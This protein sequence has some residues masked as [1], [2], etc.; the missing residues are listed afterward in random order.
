MKSFDSEPVGRIRGRKRPT[1]I[2]S[3]ESN[4]NVLSTIILPSPRRPEYQ[5]WE[6]AKLRQVVGSHTGF[7]HSGGKRVTLL[8]APITSNIAAISL[9]DSGQTLGGFW[10]DHGLTIG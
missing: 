5:F 6:Q 1:G 4:G 8:A 9:L 2:L 10:V 7:N 3:L